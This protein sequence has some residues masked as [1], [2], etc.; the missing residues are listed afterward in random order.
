MDAVISTSRGPLPSCE[1]N[2]LR[3]L[4]VV[5]ARSTNALH[6]PTLGNNNVLHSTRHWPRLT[7]LEIRSRSARTQQDGT[8]NLALL[9]ENMHAPNNRGSCNRHSTNFIA[10]IADSF[11]LN[12][13][14]NIYYFLCMFG[15]WM[16][17][18]G[19]HTAVTIDPCLRRVQKYRRILIMTEMD[20]QIRRSLKGEGLC[21][22]GSWC[23]M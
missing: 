15:T 16:S 3:M 11:V 10:A 8:Y 22:W 7:S 6:T 19:K 21:N 1:R 5:H 12:T 4:S 2:L 17:N 9:F 20:N 14:T 13:Y 18:T 23:V